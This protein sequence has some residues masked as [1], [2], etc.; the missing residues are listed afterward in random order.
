MKSHCRDD[1][2]AL[3][4]HSSIVSDPLGLGIEGFLNVYD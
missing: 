2:D 3:L 1:R 4:D